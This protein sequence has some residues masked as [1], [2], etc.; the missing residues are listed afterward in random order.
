MPMSSLAGIILAGMHFGSPNNGSFEH[1]SKQ[2]LLSSQASFQ[3][4]AKPQMRIL[5]PENITAHITICQNITIAESKTLEYQ[6]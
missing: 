4:N 2:N 1:M 5:A 6:V 3:N